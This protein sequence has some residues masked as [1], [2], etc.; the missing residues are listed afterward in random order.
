MNAGTS[1]K[2]KNKSKKKK[3][4]EVVEEPAEEVDKKKIAMAKRLAAE[5]VSGVGYNTGGNVLEL[6][7]SY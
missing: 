6:A 5:S 3:T 2:N 1:K 7:Q 4:R